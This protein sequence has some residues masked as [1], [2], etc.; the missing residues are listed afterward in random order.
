ML[1]IQQ[2]LSVRRIPRTPGP[3]SLLSTP[4]CADTGAQCKDLQLNILEILEAESQRIMHSLRSYPGTPSTFIDTWDS[5][6]EGDRLHVTLKNKNN[7]DSV[8]FSGVGGETQIHLLRYRLLAAGKILPSHAIWNERRLF[9]CFNATE[10]PTFRPFEPL[11]ERLY[12]FAVLTGFPSTSTDQS[13]ALP[14]LP[15]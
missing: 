4:V 8:E 7:D 13:N 3:D 12:Y 14:A 9:S 1:Q 15:R 2:N 11:P 10:R 6:E 5:V